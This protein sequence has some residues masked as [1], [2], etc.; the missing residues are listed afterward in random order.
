MKLQVVSVLRILS[1]TD[2]DEASCRSRAQD[3]FE[4]IV[5][6]RGAEEDK[7]AAVEEFER[8]PKLRQ[9]VHR[10]F[11]QDMG[12]ECAL[13][14]TLRQTT[15]MLAGPGENAFAASFL[16]HAIRQMMHS[17]YHDATESKVPL[18]KYVI[19]ANNAIT[20]IFELGVFADEFPDLDLSSDYH[21][22]KP[23]HA[24]ASLRKQDGFAAEGNK[25]VPRAFSGQAANS[26]V[27]SDL[28]VGALSNVVYHIRGM[29]TGAHLDAVALC[30]HVLCQGIKSLEYKVQVAVREAQVTVR[31]EASRY[32]V[33]SSMYK[34]MSHV[35]GY[36]LQES[37]SAKVVAQARAAC[38]LMRERA[39][40]D[41]NSVGLMISSQLTSM[42]RCNDS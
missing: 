33:T 38:L 1:M 32:E 17:V 26:S 25:A 6:S 34:V 14:D 15:S 35:L 37:K 4:A 5:S 36:L 10:A 11:E 3:L 16:P 13:C 31:E 18:H 23:S 19:A 8:N 2:G 39:E 12:E 42:K 7:R 30:L 24:G 27:S 40:I 21:N 41:M 22:P 20:K 9:A 29:G 28:F